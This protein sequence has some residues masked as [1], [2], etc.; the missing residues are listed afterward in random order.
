MRLKFVV[1]EFELLFKFDKVGQISKI[2]QMMTAEISK[3]YF[4]SNSVNKMP[5]ACC[6]IDSVDK[7]PATCCQ[8]DS[9][10][11]MPAACC[12]IDSV[13]KIPATCC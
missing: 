13:N 12:Q 11:K 5:A 1:S 10:N 3:K 6:H 4:L 7:M 8:I 9:V 2:I